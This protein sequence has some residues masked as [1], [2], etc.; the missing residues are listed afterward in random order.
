M[1]SAQ[2]KSAILLAGM[3]AEGT[4]TVI[5][6]PSRATTRNA[7]SAISAF[8]CSVDGLAVSTEGPALPRAHDL[9]VPADIS[10]AAFWMVA[11]ATR[12]GSV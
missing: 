3:F 4:T 8:A 7:C 6:P 12:P 10:S 2:V 9:T 5:Q 1:A 11:A